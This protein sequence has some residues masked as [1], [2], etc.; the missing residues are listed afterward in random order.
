MQVRNALGDPF[1]WLVVRILNHDGSQIYNID[2]DTLYDTSDF[3]T[4]RR[5]IATVGIGGALYSKVR[6]GLPGETRNIRARNLTSRGG[7][8]IRI[9]NNLV[10]STFTNVK[11]FGDNLVGI[12]TR[13]GNTD[14]HNVLMDEF[15]FSITQQEIF[16]S[17]ALD[18]SKFVGAVVD[19][20]DCRGDLQFKGLKVDKVNTVVKST[21]DLTV[22]VDGYECVSALK[23]AVT[24]G[25]KLVIDGKEIEN[26]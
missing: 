3:T 4:K 24:D 18:P 20:P 1:L 25:S 22:T 16:C 8:A 2:L 12:G 11:T 19:L 13:D 15:F 21:G 14:I 6:K 26:G 23:T 7:C 9:D 10:D 17:T 5:P